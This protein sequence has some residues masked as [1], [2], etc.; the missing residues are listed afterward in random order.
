MTYPHRCN[1]CCLVLITILILVCTIFAGPLL[2]ATLIYKNYIIRHDG[3][4][5][6]L[7]EPHVV[8]PS[9]YVLKIFRLRGE[10]AH[11]SFGEFLSVF[12]RLN[13]HITDIDKLHPGQLIF[14]PLKILSPEDR[15]S[16]KSDIVTI[17]FV[18]ISQNDAR[19][20]R[21]TKNYRVK[22]GDFVSKLVSKDFGRHGSTAYRQGLTLFKLLNGDINDLNRI[23]VGQQIKLVDPAIRRQPWY[24]TFFDRQFQK[25]RPK[26]KTNDNS[27]RPPKKNHL[28]PVA[29]ILDQI[30]EVLGG[31]LSKVGKYHFQ[32]E[33]QGPFTVDLAHNPMLYIDSRAKFLFVQ[34]P[35]N[36]GQKS[37]IHKSFKD[38]AII[39]LPNDSTQKEKSLASEKQPEALLEAIFTR[40]GATHSDATMARTIDG[41]D[42]KIRP[43]WFLSTPPDD[44]KALTKTALTLLDDPSQRLPKPIAQ[45]LA[46]NNIA[47]HELTRQPGY[48]TNFE[49]KKTESRPKPIT[50]DKSLDTATDKPVSIKHVLSVMGYRLTPDASI[51]FPYAGIQITARSNLVT[52]DNM[53]P[54]FV[55]FGELYGEAIDAIE[56]AGFQMLHFDRRDSAEKIVPALLRKLGIDFIVNPEFAAAKRPKRYNALFTI[57]GYLLKEMKPKKILIA[58]VPV[59]KTLV[60]LLT[61]QG[62]TV[63]TL[64]KPVRL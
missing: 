46:D 30:V 55:D 61:A 27:Y 34:S 59:K 22:P 16:Q 54:L 44:L 29:F 5:K 15:A 40:L 9:E 6:I 42:W 23:A 60:D 11:R 36:E 53:P 52:A 17:P 35:L 14:L 38:L 20:K 24:E 28:T 13:P 26:P 62:I 33:R 57:P 58:L 10:I 37:S 63:Y 43:Q 32:T 4:H 48:Y 25:A 39:L 12:K 7:C 2:G 21:F 64:R 8:K 50:T 56:K 49:N 47:I 41:I 51:R 31:R 45:Y 3:N 19:L 1:A 18:S